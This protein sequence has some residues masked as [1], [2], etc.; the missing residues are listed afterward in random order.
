MEHPRQLP[1]AVPAGRRHAS[2]SRHIP[3]N[4]MQ[5]KVADYIVSGNWSK[6]AFKEAKLYGDA[7]CIASSE[8]EN[9]T[10]VPDCRRPH[11]QPRRRLRLHLP[12][13]DRLRQ[14]LHQ[15]ARNRRHPAGL[16]RF[17]HVPLRAHGRVEVRPDLRRR[18]EERRPGRRGHRH[19]ARR[20]DHARTCCPSRPP[21]MRYKTQ[22]D[23]GSHVQHAR[24]AYGIYMCG[25]VFQWLQGP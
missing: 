19:R 8:D 18:A 15:A 11:V 14:P 3:M 12:E 1:R 22:A 9:F 24:R 10:Y 4:L 16:R 23:A 25:K 20:P 2:S 17:Q 6:K 5:N 7:S 13:R 21:C